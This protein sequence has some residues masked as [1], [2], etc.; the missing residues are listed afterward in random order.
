ML[1]DK[2][3]LV[4]FSRFIE[5]MNEELMNSALYQDGMQFISVGSG[6]DFITPRLSLT[7]NQGL[8]KWVFDRVSTK[9]T[10]TRS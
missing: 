5:L 9:Y 4:L 2:K 8:D 7:E 1:E 6:Y 10:I 3:R